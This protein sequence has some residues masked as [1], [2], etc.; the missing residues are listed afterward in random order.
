MAREVSVSVAIYGVV[1]QSP[2]LFTY[3]VAS[4]IVG[5]MPSLGSTAG[6]T[7]VIVYGISFHTHG[8]MPGVCQC[9]FGNISVPGLVVNSTAIECMSP[10]S[11][12]LSSGPVAIGVSLDRQNISPTV[13]FTYISP[14][15]IDSIYPNLGLSRGGS[16][17]LVHG[18]GRSRHVA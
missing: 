4:S 1:L 18:S 8:S 7:V 17:V 6:G 16:S 9:I 12:F 5:V 13:I 11:P 14:V 10:A 3:Q 15:T 2:I